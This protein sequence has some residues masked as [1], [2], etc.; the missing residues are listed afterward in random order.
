ML[1]RR[2]YNHGI[3]TDIS[4]HEQLEQ[5][6][7]FPNKLDLFAATV[8]IGASEVGMHVDTSPTVHKGLVVAAALGGARVL[9]RMFKAEGPTEQPLSDEEFAAKFD[10]LD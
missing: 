6:I 8:A 3:M 9:W 4:S 1:Y 7:D 2:F 5:P 10:I